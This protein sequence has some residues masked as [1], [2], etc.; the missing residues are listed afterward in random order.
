MQ[1]HKNAT[2]ENLKRAKS[3]T[4]SDSD[5]QHPYRTEMSLVLSYNGNK[6]KYSTSQN[7]DKTQSSDIE[8]PP[9]NLPH[10]MKLLPNKLTYTGKND[11]FKPIDTS[12]VAEK[13]NEHTEN[14]ANER[15]L[16]KS[17]AVSLELS[18]GN[19]KKA[20]GRKN[21][22]SNS[23]ND[24]NHEPESNEDV[25]NANSRRHDDSNSQLT[26]NES[27]DAQESVIVLTFLF[28]NS[29]KATNKLRYLCDN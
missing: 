20:N 4:S 19:N 14:S 10:A 18:N 1:M 15:V 5:Q 7:S 27:N 17:Q 24:E 25:T 28:E 6:S 23:K 8:T 16:T 12:Q 29:I 21:E 22:K 13:S 9:P 3:S 26:V 2:Y 11:L